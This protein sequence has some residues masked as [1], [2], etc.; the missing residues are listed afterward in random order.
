MTANSEEQPELLSPDPP[1]CR[2]A[3]VSPDSPRQAYYIVS[4]IQIRD[5]YVIRKESGGNQ[6]KPQIESY[7]R[8]G[9]K[10]ALEKY[11]LLLGAKLRKQKGR[12]YKVA[13]EKKNEKQKSSGKN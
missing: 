5:G 3:L 12:T 8:P 6:A 2:T 10:L 4:V 9:L 13:L 7:W 11:N 1:V